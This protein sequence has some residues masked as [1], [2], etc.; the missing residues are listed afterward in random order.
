MLR[1][2]WLIPLFLLLF[3]CQLSA[4]PNN[5]VED[6]SLFNPSALGV[7]AKQ[8]AKLIT[9]ET[10]FE[11][12]RVSH[13]PYR[14]PARD[15]VA[16]GEDMIIGYTWY[17]YQHNGSIGKM[18]ARDS[19]G[20]THFT[21]M[22]GFDSQQQT[23][24]MVYN[25]LDPDGGL[26]NGPED[27]G[28][29]DN[30]TRSGYG[31]IALLPE[32]ERAG[33][34]YHL[35]GHRENDPEYLG[36]ALSVDWMSG[37][38]AFQPSYP[39]AWPEV[40]LAWP[41]GTFD[42]RNFAHMTATE[43]SPEEQ[44]WQRVSYWRG[45]PDGEFLNWSW[46][47][48]QNAVEVDV[49][50]VISSVVCA[51]KQSNKVALAWHQNRVGMDLGPWD[52]YRGAWQRNNDIRYIISEDGENWD[53]DEGIES[54]TKIIPPNPDLFDIDLQEAYGDTFR[55]YCD[56]DIQFDPWEGGDNLY[57]VFSASGFRELPFPDP[58]GAPLDGMYSEQCYL[59]FWSSHGGEDEADT[60]TVIADG[61]YSN[62]SDNPL[63][64]D[65]RSRRQGVWRTNADRGSLAFDAENPG[66]I[67][68]VWVN[69]PQ[70]MEIQEDENGELFW[71]Y[72]EGAQDTSE[73][74]YNN[75]E[76]MVSISNDFGIHW[77]QP[78]N[79]TQT[80]WEGDDA[81]V[82]GECMSENWSSVA[83]VADGALHI[84]YVRDG[85]AGGIPQEEGT[86]T[87][88]PVI[89]HTILLEDLP[90]NEFVEIPEGLMFHN[91]PDFAP[92]IDEIARDRGTVLPNEAV[93]VSSEVTPLGGRELA[94]V[95]LEY[96][97]ITDGDDD[98]LSVAMDADG[99]TYTAEI[100]GMADGS[101]V[102]YRITANDDEDGESTKPDGYWFAY[103][104]R[105]A[106]GLQIRDIQYRP[107]EWQTDYSSY[108]DYEVTVT[109][110]VTTPQEFN[111]SI[112]GMAIQDQSAA[113]SGVYVR[114]ALRDD[115]VPGDL[116]SVTG[117]VTERDEDDNR[118]RWG[119]YINVENQ[120]DIVA[121]GDG[122]EIVPIDVSIQDIS[123]M[124]FLAEDLEAVLVRL[125][126][127]QVD[128]T[129]NTDFPTYIPITEEGEEPEF[130]AWMTTHGLSEDLIGDIGIET[131]AHGTVVCWM[132]GVFSENQR[133]AIAPRWGEDIGPFSAPSEVEPTP[134][135]F[136]L[137]PAYPNPFNSMTNVGFEISRA[138][139]VNLA[140]YDLAGRMVASVVEGNVPA[141][142]FNSTLDASQLSTGVYILR[143]DTETAS[144][145]QKLV[146]VK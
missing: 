91:Y 37:I 96:V 139:W 119:T 135:K 44:L 126:H 127:F 18:V 32:D 1:K 11:V 76:I 112:G 125:D 108:K 132:V 131:F 117:V 46:N 129:D 120:D 41:K 89:Y 3:V 42:F 86:A 23:R 67:Y 49:A 115:V 128:V 29:V 82:P 6:N 60:I 111:S 57:G 124:D 58:D 51:S 93:N 146:L 43:N 63:M 104:V 140:V 15:P 39:D 10:E 4:R 90:E 64:P 138:G 34:F 121:I 74:G 78:I 9:P 62:V 83:E 77:R 95:V 73:A 84:M 14:D 19:Q 103:V 143:L 30:A 88:S 123:G 75:A 5:A 24:H 45:V 87:N 2:S 22:C 72:L 109:G 66:T 110:V 50:G 94:D 36:S 116:V 68:C 102:W 55:P 8:A 35:T 71:A 69:F 47:N 107:R 20:G 79:V 52:E 122:E 26:L 81:P 61:W 106:D 118:W 53:W 85:D 56:I 113:W 100:P 33:V 98:T 25:Y 31:C 80:V 54:L 144:A 92:R 16:I 133:Y 142:H 38:G 134:A 99:D 137:D 13:V 136:A 65:N 48:G 97:V 21:W 70:I 27:R 28:V 130:S 105:P 59:W 114:G 141:G 7:D 145:S 40:Q 101:Y 12:D 17:D